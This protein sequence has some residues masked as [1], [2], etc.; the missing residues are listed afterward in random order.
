MIRRA[1]LE[2]TA[3]QWTED[4]FDELDQFLAHPG[5]KYFQD[6]ESACL[7]VNFKDGTVPTPLIMGKTDWIVKTSR[8]ETLSVCPDEEF[9]STYGP[10]LPTA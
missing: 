1:L 4:N 2:V 6:R 10:L 5:T 7:I 3:V 8:R 9:L